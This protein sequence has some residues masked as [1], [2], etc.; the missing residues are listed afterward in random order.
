[1]DTR[2]G[3]HSDII[4]NHNKKYQC[5]SP[6]KIRLGAQKTLFRWNSITKTC[7][8]RSLPAKSNWFE[9]KRNTYAVLYLDSTW[10]CVRIVYTLY[11]FHLSLYKMRNLYFVRWVW[12]WTRGPIFCRAGHSLFFS[13]FALR[14]P[15]NFYPWI[16]IALPLILWV[17]KNF[18]NFNV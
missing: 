5:D 17:F 1:M 18:Y 14:S 15:L 12:W 9:Q 3:F 6:F 2:E 13:R 16:A 8:L 4:I 11:T 7:S 10:P